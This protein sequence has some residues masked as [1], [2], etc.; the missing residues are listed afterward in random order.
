MTKVP[1]RFYRQ[2]TY[3]KQLQAYVFTDTNAFIPTETSM[4][5]IFNSPTKRNFRYNPEIR[6]FREVKPEECDWTTRYLLCQDVILHQMAEQTDNVRQ[7]R[8]GQMPNKWINDL[9]F[10]APVHDWIIGQTWLPW[11]WTSTK[12]IPK[13]Y[14]FY[15]S[16]GWR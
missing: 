15:R 16:C 7:G 3:D 9:W 14:K 13:K 2:V 12:W 10:K 8:N 6:K 5:G 11:L 4:D 1:H